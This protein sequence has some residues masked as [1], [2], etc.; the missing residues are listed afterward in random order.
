M[1]SIEIIEIRLTQDLNE[2]LE[3]EIGNVIEEVMKKESQYTLK[4][5]NKMKLR[6]DYM[7]I[8]FH[9]QKLPSNKKSELGQQLRASLKD[10]GMIN[11][12][13]WTELL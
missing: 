6:S 8:I 13:V 11:H 1:K 4:L 5:Y 10:F 9:T 3:K 7:I 2:V 12:N